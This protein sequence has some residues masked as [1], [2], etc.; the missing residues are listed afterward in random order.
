MTVFIGGSA[1]VEHCRLWT[2]QHKCASHPQRF[3]FC[4][5]L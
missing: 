3:I 5:K 2:P 1:L 4:H